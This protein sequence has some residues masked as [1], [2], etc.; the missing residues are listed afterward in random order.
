M[1]KDLYKLFKEKKY[2]EVINVFN[3]KDDLDEKLQNLKAICFYALN[4]I[5]STKRIFYNLVQSNNHITDPY[6]NLVTILFSEQ[7][8]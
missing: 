8:L 1:E 5:D 4:N 7:T 6:I 2:Q 3:N